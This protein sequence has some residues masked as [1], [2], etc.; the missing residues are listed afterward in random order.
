VQEILFMKRFAV[1]LLVCLLVAGTVS[2]FSMNP[3]SAGASKAVVTTTAVP[4]NK[5]AG[6]MVP[7]SIAT[8]PGRGML[9]VYSVPSG[10]AV[11]VS[12]TGSVSGTTPAKFSLYAGTYTV[13]VSLAGYRDYTET[14]TLDTGAIKGINADL[15]K[16][17]TGVS[18]SNI[19]NAAASGTIRPADTRPVSRG[20]D[21][22]PLQLNLY[23]VPSGATVSIRDWTVP[24]SLYMPNGTTPVTKFFPPGS[25]Q[26]Q[27]EKG[28]YGTLGALINLS[29]GDPPRN[30]TASLTPFNVNDT[31]VQVYVN[32]V[33]AGA[34]VYTQ[35]NAYGDKAFICTTPCS[36]F[37]LATGVYTFTLTKPDYHDWTAV[38]NLTFGMPAQYINASLTPLNQTVTPTVTVTSGNASIYPMAC[39][40]SD[41]TCL[42]P[43]GAAQ[44]FGYP[45]ARYGDAPCG[46]AQENGQTVNKYCFM[47]VDSGGNLPNNALIAGSI[48]AGDDIYIINQTWVE[49][50]V[51]NKSPLLQEAEPSTPFQSIFS[52]F[53]NMFGGGK[54]SPEAR[55]QHVGLN[56]QPEPPAQDPLVQNAK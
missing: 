55:L 31:V 23:S 8:T 54:I 39:P 34:N 11:T 51:V 28:G 50:A 49:H 52:F 30:F 35:N 5:N 6:A 45:N 3:G 41:W 29:A 25:Y 27:F 46:Y 10:A 47:D 2:A 44:Q 9:E 24:G 16:S 18:A 38:Y 21:S 32:S 17:L 53:N 1:L 37:N 20:T 7:V 33:P 40:N 48:R 43:A 26:V 22:P 56:P 19:A 4:I 15:Q 14:F 42:T 13:K 12:G 36:P